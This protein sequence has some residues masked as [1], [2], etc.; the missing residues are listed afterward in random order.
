[1]FVRRPA[2]QPV[3]DHWIYT[4]HCYLHMAF[5]GQVRTGRYNHII[6]VEEDHVESEVHHILDQQPVA[7]LSSVWIAVLYYVLA[8]RASYSSPS[9]R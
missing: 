1:M 5:G 2:H 7:T 9:S 4:F 3:K 8:Y 6:Y